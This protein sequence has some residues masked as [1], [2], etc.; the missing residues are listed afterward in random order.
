MK[1]FVES[2]II[3]D[4]HLSVCG[5]T[6][7]SGIGHRKAPNAKEEGWPQQGRVGELPAS[8]PGLGHDSSNTEGTQ[9]RFRFVSEYQQ[10]HGK[11]IG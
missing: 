1:L 9:N 6:T 4:I 11:C 8:A 5:K 10:G 3:F 7:D 2:V